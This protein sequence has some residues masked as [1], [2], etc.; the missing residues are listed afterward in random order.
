MPRARDAVDPVVRVDS[1]VD[2]QRRVAGLRGGRLERCEGAER[3]TVARRREPE[4]ERSHQTTTPVLSRPVRAG[5]GDKDT[6]SHF[7]KGGMQLADPADAGSAFPSL[8]SCVPL[9]ALRTL[10]ALPSKVLIIIR[11]PPDR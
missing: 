2:R 6:E 10:F 4:L 9:P 5:H 1:Q 3:V 8:I 7:I 11:D